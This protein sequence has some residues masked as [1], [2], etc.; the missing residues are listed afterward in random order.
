MEWGQDW[1]K[2]S[3]WAEVA[4]AME[5]GQDWEKQSPLPRERP[6]SRRGSPQKWPLEWESPAWAWRWRQSRK[7]PDPEP[8][9]PARLR[10]RH[11]SSDAFLRECGAGQARV[12][13]AKRWL[14]NWTARRGRL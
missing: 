14:L 1:E 13:P 9:S 11:A 8:T 7:P 3:P 2:Q 5:W 12:C 4:S 6:P 10:E